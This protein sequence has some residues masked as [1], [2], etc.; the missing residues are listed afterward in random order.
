MIALRHR[1]HPTPRLPVVGLFVFIAACNPNP[2]PVTTAKAAPPMG[3]PTE[4]A[5]PTPVVT[6]SVALIASMH[7]R[8]RT[9]WYHSLTFVQ[10]TSVP[11]ASGGDMIQTWYEAGVLPGQLR[12]DTDLESRSGVLYAKDSVFRFT[13]GKLTQSD[14]GMNEL[15]VL[16]FDVY[17]QPPEQT[18]RIL[19]HLGFDLAKMH[20]TT[21]QGKAVYVVGATLGDTTSK[22]FWIEKE[23][24]LFVRMLQQNP[25]RGQIEVRFE[26]YVPAG[27]AWIAMQVEQF[28]NGKRTLLEEYSDVKTDVQLPRELFDPKQWATVAHWSKK[29]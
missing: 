2:T 24:L 28:V 7:E 8:Y 11:R 15:L 12:I 1:S 17:V 18:E 14:T 26:K 5:P 10:K 16:G 21:W 25:R 19:R 22:Q 20:Q 3:P 23:R 29:S 6:N 27:K 13:N 9:T 4:V